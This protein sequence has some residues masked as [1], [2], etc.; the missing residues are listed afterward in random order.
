MTGTIGQQAEAA[1][2]STP[3]G[4]ATIASACRN[5]KNGRM[6]EWKDGRME[7]WKDGRMEGWKDGRMEGWKDGR[8]EGW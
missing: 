7:G 6:E 4:V 8:M 1:A 3:G 5:W 2:E